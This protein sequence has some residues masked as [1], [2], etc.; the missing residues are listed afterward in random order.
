MRPCIERRLLVLLL[1][2]PAAAGFASPAAEFREFVPKGFALRAAEI[3]EARKTGYRLAAKGAGVAYCARCG[4]AFGDPFE[5]PAIRS[6]VLTIHNYGGS[7]LRWGHSYS[8]RK[9]K[10][11]YRLISYSFSTFRSAEE[12]TGASLDYDLVEGRAALSRDYI[13]PQT[14]ECKSDDRTVEVPARE[15]FLENQAS[16]NLQSEGSFD[17]FFRPRENQPGKMPD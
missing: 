14:N 13:S 1:I 9:I 8:F 15:L 5:D 11:A 10:G 7:A 6:G 4:G 12:C 16:W 2:L 3:L 17:W